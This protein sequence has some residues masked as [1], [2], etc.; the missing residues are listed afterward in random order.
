MFYRRFHFAMIGVVLLVA[1]QFCAQGAESKPT[2]FTSSTELVLIPTVVHDKS[3][4]H[5]SGLGK[6]EFV[7]KQDGKSQPL[8]IF[9]EVNTNSYRLHRSAGEN[10][11]FSNV[12]PS[13]S[14]EHHRVSIIV[15]DFVN[16]PFA[17]QSSARSALL[18]FLSQVADSGEPMCLLALGSN[19]LTL[20]H[21]FTD[22]PK[23]LAAGIS[24]ARD[25][26]AP[27]IHQGVEDA[28]HPVD[29]PLAA[30]LTRLIRGQLQSDEE[31]ATQERKSAISVTIEALRQIAK[32]FRGLPG[33]K[34]LIWAS[35]GFPFSQEDGM[36]SSYD[37][38][39]RMMNDAQI[40]IY[41][42]DLRSTTSNLKI[43]DDRVRASDI[44]DSQF[45]TG[46]LALDELHN[47]N[48]T[49][50]MFA[51]STGGKAFLGGGNLVQSFRQAIQ[52]DSS[53]YVL[54]YYVHRNNTK[55]GWHD[56]AVAVQSKG[57]HARYRKGFFL[58]TDTSAASARQEIQEALR[59]PLDY[60]GVPVSLTWS[61]KEPGKTPGKTKVKFDLVM[62]AGFAT[63]NESD[64]NH[65]VVDVAAVARNLNGDVV[66]DL[67]QRI[68]SHL[69]S[70]HLEQMQHNG[71]TYRNGL[72]LPPGKYIVRFVVR[73]SLSNR[74]G[75]VAAPI[76]VS[77]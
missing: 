18:Q 10:G 74:L 21:D 40:A 23:L 27:L 19:G 42:V 54:G 22:D 62:P 68:E 52:D 38:L 48:S 6:G 32:A 53:Y 59:S 26:T 28:N 11:T 69:K 1:T 2:T 13:R 75:S 57:A 3:G 8:A 56:V 45:D 20:L 41:S 37:N 36:Q 70:D 16:T 7:L 24:K 33:R 65:M 44:G 4:S 58:S 76:T 39:W 17:D 60:S 43:T 67:S 73:D 63:I 15:L 5:I 9:E 46:A 61:G 25:H 34:S 50:Q 35:S 47:A 12:N 14:G 49:L 71:M 66:A 31:L 77:P 64:D 72:Q 55:P 51:E 29:G 30:T